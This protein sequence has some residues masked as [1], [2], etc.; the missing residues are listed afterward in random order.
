MASW[1]LWGVAFSGLVLLVDYLKALLAKKPQRGVR[2]ENGDLRCCSHV[3]CRSYGPLEKR[4]LCPKSDD[5][6]VSLYDMFWRQVAENPDRPLFGYRSVLATIPT[7]IDG[8]TLEKYTLSPY[9]WLTFKQV[10]VRV[11]ALASGLRALGLQPGNFVGFYCDTCVEWSM[12]LNAV[13]AQS[14]VGTTVYANIGLDGIAHAFSQTQLEVLF[15][16]HDLLPTLLK[17]L[18]RPGHNIHT[19][20]YKG[21]ADQTHVDQLV[22][23]GVRLITYADLEILGQQ[24]PVEHVPPKADD[25][26]IVMYTS[27]TTGVP[28]GVVLT[29]ANVLSGGTATHH[30]AKIGD[31]P[32]ETYL[33]FLPSA[34]IFEIL[35]EFIQIGH[36]SKIGFANRRTLT[37]EFVVNCLGDIAELRPT[38][39]CAVPAVYEKIRKGLYAKIRRQSFPVR[40]LFHVGITLKMRLVGRLRYTFLAKILCGLLDKIIFRKIQASLGGRLRLLVTGGAPLSRN[41]QRFFTACFSCPCLGGYGMTETASVITMSDLDDC[42]FG[43]CGA[44]VC[45]CDIKLKDVPELDYTSK[46]KPYPAGE[47]CVRGNQIARGYFKLPAE[48]AEVFSSDGYLCTGDIGRIHPDGCL[49]IIDRKKNVVKLAHG[50]YLPLE[51]LECSYSRSSFVE[52]ICLCADSTR[53]YAVAL[54]LPAKTR[55]ESFYKKKFP[56]PEEFAKACQNPALNKAV[57]ESLEHTAEETHIPR[58]QR[59]ARVAIIGD[60]WTPETGLVTSALK[61]KRA[62]I[63]ARYAQLIENLYKD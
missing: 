8:R 9:K 44:P 35:S 23:K 21:D 30:C 20:I 6:S 63:S 5:G 7:T 50:E 43:R 58:N 1:W 4:P 52:N 17:L 57:M 46:S 45:S 24:H 16:S 42:T 11:T 36:N 51:K 60:E 32:D 2:I 61:L 59:V 29:H 22:S 12:L 14:M 10:S 3:L 18:D 31:F 41:T 15:T 47:V 49:E 26:C 40:V 38:V 48:T 62:A 56:D 34:H 27:G 54:I 53:D 33:A 55:V 39:I 19:I 25:D 28:K 37:D 13:F